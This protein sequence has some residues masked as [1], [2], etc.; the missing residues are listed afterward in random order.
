[1]STRYVPFESKSGFQ[2][3]GFSV[4]EVGD[5]TVSGSV[6]TTGSFKINGIPIIDPSDSRI[7]L[8]PVIE[9]ALGLTEIG[10]LQYLN[11]NGDLVVSHGSSQ[12]ITVQNGTGTIE[13][14]S[15]GNQ[16]PSTGNFTSVTVAELEIAS[17]PT[18]PTQATRKDYVDSRISA[19]AIAFGA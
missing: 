8:D 5:L 15:I 7:G 12:I 14:T 3:P 17:T 6:N 16:F 1:M 11:V 18:L 10:T 9:R 19:F 4:N 2:S 13:Y